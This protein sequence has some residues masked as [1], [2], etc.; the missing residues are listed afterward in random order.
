MKL[1]SSPM[2]ADGSSVIN[3]TD[4]VKQLL[5]QMGKILSALP[6][7][8]MDKP[9]AIRASWP[10]YNQ[11]G[12]VVSSAYRRSSKPIPSER[13]ISRAEYWL[14][15]IS[16]LDTQSRSIVMA[17]AIGITWRRLEE[18]DGRSHTTLRK[19]EQVALQEILVLAQ[20]KS[21]VDK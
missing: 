17:R 7:T 6:L 11:K 18:M 15:V 8:Q 12:C 2:L 13:D 3:K 4:Q 14:N 9:M 1:A 21:N 16:G 10:D 20:Q 19:I 5:R